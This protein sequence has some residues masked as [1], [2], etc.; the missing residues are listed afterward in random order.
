MNPAY[1]PFPLVPNAEPRT[2]SNPE[3]LAI[4]PP[5]ALALASRRAPSSLCRAVLRPASL[6]AIILAIC[7][8]ALIAGVFGAVIAVPAVAV[9]VVALA[10]LAPVQRAAVRYRAAREHE[11]RERERLARLLPAG[12]VRQQEYRELREIVDHLVRAA[13]DD[14]RRF[15]L[16]Q[17]LDY[18]VQIA[19]AHE[20]YQRAVQAAAALSEESPKG[21]PERSARTREL[22][23]RRIRHREE[24][25][26]HC[27]HLVDQLD[28]I[29][30]LVR[31]VAQRAACLPVDDDLDG[32]IDRR[33]CELDEVD[34]A[35]AQ[36]SA[37]TPGVEGH[38][39]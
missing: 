33:L 35:L 2:H 37:Y 28:A 30:Q 20:R 13:P 10:S 23:T 11:T 27:K 18:F 5:I 15:D 36:M 3:A 21:G 25:K 22:V 26:H 16:E 32:E 8:G 19:F 38:L 4:L 14:A 12:P 17:L 39:G 7:V 24:S 6:V 9:A 34:A 31:L 29:D 1:I